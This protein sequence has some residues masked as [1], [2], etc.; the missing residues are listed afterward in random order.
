MITM[1]FRKKSR[2]RRPIKHRVLE[3][4]GMK[5]LKKKGSIADAGPSLFL[6]P[7]MSSDDYHEIRHLERALVMRLLALLL[8]T[9]HLQTHLRRALHN[10]DMQYAANLAIRRTCVGI[11]QM[12]CLDCGLADFHESTTYKAI[13]G[14][15]PVY[16]CDTI[17]GG[18]RVVWRPGFIKKRHS[19]V[20]ITDALVDAASGHPP[21]RICDRMAKKMALA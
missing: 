20:I 4:I 16:R 17:R 19:D 15:V 21:A 6:V 5:I 13:R 18:K 3:S 8:G 12:P 2:K 1:T 14:D 7:S 9:H 10:N 11:P